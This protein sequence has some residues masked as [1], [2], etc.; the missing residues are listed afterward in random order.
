MT[1]DRPTVE[2][3]APGVLAVRYEWRDQL[4]AE[5]QGVLLDRALAS[6]DDGP[7]AL[8]FM[9]ADRIREIPPNVRVFWRTITADH[10]YRVAAVA[11]V[12]ASW[13][14]EVS[15]KGFGV[16]NA[17]SGA[18]VRVQTFVDEQEAVAWAAGVVRPVVA[19]TPA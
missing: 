5:L 17:L 15:A 10:R 13:A 4:S 9:L 8:V 16:T 14:V 3:P 7:I 19:A 12:T 6:T 11:V 2:Q 1:V 18:P